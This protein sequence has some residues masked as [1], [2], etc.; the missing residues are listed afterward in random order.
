MSTRSFAKWAAIVALVAGV[1]VA[2][3]ADIDADPVALSMADFNG[4]IAFDVSLTPV[5]PLSYDIAAQLSLAAQLGWFSLSSET[6]FSLSGF[7]SQR[8]ILGVALGAIVLT[9][10]IDFDP[11]FSW[12]QLAMDAEFLGI[13]LGV[14]LILADI[15][16]APPA[17]YS[18]AG[19]LELT[20]SF[21]FGVSILS[22][23]GFGATDLLESHLASATPLAANLLGLL[24]HV[25]GL[26]IDEETPNPTI[27]SGFY[28]EEQDLQITFSSL[29]LLLS[30][31][32]EFSWT[33]ISKQTI[34]FGFQFDDPQIAFLLALALDV[35]LAV[36]KIDLLVDL[37][38]FPVRFTSHTVFAA[39]VPPAALP[40]QFEAQRFGLGVEF[41]GALWTTALDFDS[42]FLFERLQVGVEAELGP[43]MIVSL[44]AFD[45]TGFEEQC[46]RANMTFS[47]IMLSTSVRF[48]MSG[49]VEL[50][51]GF[52]LSF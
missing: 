12:N 47:G 17:V 5:P 9:E 11:A 38:V 37:Q 49:L 44:T 18:M 25:D 34:E 21:D 22:L 3:W 14:D 39:P 41:L 31:T 52:A 23:T 16:A 24:D 40:V 48:D 13:A 51:F 30:S 6:Q 28:F 26:C 29:G 15:S 2:G 8:L 27:L 4:T 7:E 20:T 1:G 36:D 45:A 10:R 50:M 19:I 42:T 35:P 43:A 33:G 32:T 46:L